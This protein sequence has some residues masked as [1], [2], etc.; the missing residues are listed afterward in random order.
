MITF[1]TIVLYS[2]QNIPA[3]NCHYVI[4]AVWLIIKSI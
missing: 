1:H 2:E 3:P 4:Q